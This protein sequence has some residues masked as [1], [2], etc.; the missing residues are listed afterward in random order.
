[1]AAINN[2]PSSVLA[3]AFA[4]VKAAEA[5]SQQPSASQNLDDTYGNAVNV[6]LSPPAQA[7]ASNQNT[8]STA[9]SSNSGAD[10]SAPAHRSHTPHVPI[11]S[12]SNE[13][14]A[15]FLVEEA[16]QQVIPKV[17]V[18]DAS[19]VVDSNGNINQ[20][21]LQELIAQQEQSQSVA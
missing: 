21:K 7:I 11:T 18:T 17:G 8:S 16:L 9:A 1:M 19:E 14:D 12:V 13:T 20:V 10:T 15:T 6:T 4:A 5:Q 3:Q 2:I